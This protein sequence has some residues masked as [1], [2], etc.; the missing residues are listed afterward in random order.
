MRAIIILFLGAVVMT[1]CA[2]KEPAIGVGGQ[3]AKFGDY[4]RSEV[5]ALRAS[6]AK[7]TFPVP[8]HTISKMLPRPVDPLATEFVDWMPDPAK[9]GRAGGNV[10]E[11]WL[12]SD[13]VLKVATAYYAEG[14]KHF[15]REEWA[16][17]LTRAER[18][19]YRGRI[20]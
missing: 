18:D 1:G 7:L 8:E 14:E 9:K 16:V 5:E 11:Y 10:V 20:Y 12:S 4:S 6:I 15:S 13:R 17:I 19:R 3:P 2:K